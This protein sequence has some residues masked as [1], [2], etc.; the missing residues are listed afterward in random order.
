MS[1]CPSSPKGGRGGTTRACTSGC[2][3]S[4]REGSL[5]KARRLCGAVLVAGLALPPAAASAWWNDDW[6]GRK[7]LR[8]DTSAAGA[9]VTEPIGAAPVLVRL[10]AGNF[11]FEAAK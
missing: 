3:A 10:H 6:S 7:L 2:V 11:K 8:V 9:D 1:A 4:S 5:M